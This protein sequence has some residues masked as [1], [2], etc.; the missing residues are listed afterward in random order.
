M[1]AQKFAVL[2]FKGSRSISVADVDGISE[3]FMTYFHPTGY[4]P[5]ERA[6]I[7]KVIFEQ[8]FQHSDYTTEQAVHLGELL[9]ASKV[10]L[11]KVSMLGGQYQVDVRVVDVQLGHDVAFEGATFS[12]DYRT[13]VRNLATNLAS[14]IAISSGGNVQQTTSVQKEEQR[15]TPY[16]IY[17][18]LK[19]FPTDI[20]TFERE[21][22]QIISR[23]NQSK[24]YE[25]GT[26][27]LPTEEELQLMRANN[28]VGN[29]LYM[30]RENKKGILRLVTD[31]EK[32]EVM[33][34]EYVDLGLP[35]G[36][37]W[38]DRNENER[39]SNMYN[40]Y[41]YFGGRLPSKEQLE[42]L[43]EL[44]QWIWLGN[45]YKVIGP[46]GDY[47]ILPTICVGGDAI[48][49]CLTGEYCSQDYRFIQGCY[50]FWALSFNSSKIEVY[51]SYMR[52]YSGDLYIR[53]VQ[54]P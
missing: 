42:E 7:D 28:I 22:R 21:P 52:R 41:R 8:N 2:E 19:V 20:G 15:A 12:G 13:N 39:Y 32:G 37:L 43:K 30:T 50:Y 3:M 44:C 26:W 33:S 40:A 49:D 34:A 9:N 10:V 6:Q 35:S 24:Q 4:T 31:K 45:G 23:I 25:Y 27:R 11:G 54:N 36:T 14:K 29:D 17:G 5:I 18:Y 51:D 1:N 38:K 46:N 16:L 48:D 47:I 53:L